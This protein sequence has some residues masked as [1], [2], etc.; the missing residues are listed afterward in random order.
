MASGLP[1]S[2]VSVRVG[3]RVIVGDGVKVGVSVIVVDVMVVKVISV[4]IDGGISPTKMVTMLDSA[5]PPPSR[6]RVCIS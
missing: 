6:R 5:V 2:D 1:D 3:V 4:V